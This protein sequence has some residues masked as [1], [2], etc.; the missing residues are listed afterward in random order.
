MP[1]LY[2]IRIFLLFI[3]TT[4]FAQE[5]EIVPPYNIRTV[6]L[7]QNGQ[8]IVPIIRLGDPFQLEFDDLFGNEANYYYTITH[9]DYDWKPSQFVKS[10]YLQ[11]FEDIRIQTYTN[12]FNA[13]QI[14]SHYFLALPNKNTSL[15]V[16][17][18]YVIKILNEDKEVVFSR[19]FIMYEDL[20]SV[21]MQVKR[22]RTV[23]AI[24]F[25]QNLD[26]A[27]KSPNILFQSPL[28]NVKVLLL[29]NGQLSTAITNVP[30][31]YTI[32]ND[33]IYKYDTETQFW[34]GN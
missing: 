22:T 1:R 26:F 8:N 4:T 31:M 16:S 7:V 18:N 10:E 33:L 2:F 27:I 29:K 13:L 5:R 23:S 25:K 12:S 11:G 32:G 24:N 21:P 14:Y 28:K 34:G 3:A 30:A 19:K 9:C 20:V 15:L 6:A 17:G